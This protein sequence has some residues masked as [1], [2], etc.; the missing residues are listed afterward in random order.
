MKIFFRKTFVPLF[1][2]LTCPP[3]AILFFYINT[4]LD[5][6]ITQFYH[7]VTQQG[8]FTTL[9]QIWQPVFFG[10]RDA[11]EMIGA[12]MIT[13]LILMRVVPGK[14]VT[15]PETP[16]GNIPVYK[17]NGFACFLITIAL[18]FLCVQCEL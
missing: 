4:Q 2:M 11:W 8:F 16:K 12:F 17:N 1:L 3:A 14:K 18:F 5:G 10:T 6:S 9:W 13:Q 7:L 15:G